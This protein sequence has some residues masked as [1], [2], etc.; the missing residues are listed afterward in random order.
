MEDKERKVERGNVKGKGNKKGKEKQT[1]KQQEKEKEKYKRK[2]KKGTRER[3]W[4]RKGKLHVMAAVQKIKHSERLSHPFSTQTFERTKVE[5]LIF[6]EKQKL[7][8]AACLCRKLREV[9]LSMQ[10]KTQIQTFC[11]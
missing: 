9:C 11:I 5:D 6:T 3:T 7:P 4:N 1:N 2:N 10:G 8:S